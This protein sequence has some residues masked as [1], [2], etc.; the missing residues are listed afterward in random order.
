MEQGGYWPVQAS[1]LL[2]FSIPKNLTSGRAS[3]IVA[4]FDSLVRMARVEDKKR[5]NVGFHGRKQWRTGN[6][7]LGSSARITK[8]TMWRRW[9][10]EQSPFVVDLTQASGTRN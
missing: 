3:C 5:S 7:S 6:T 8:I 9:M 10:R 2:F 1:S 4:H